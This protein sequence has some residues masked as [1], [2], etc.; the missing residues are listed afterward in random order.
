MLLSSHEMKL[1]C[2][3]DRLQ[4]QNGFS[5]VDDCIAII[6]GMAS[7]IYRRR[8]PKRR[9]EQSKQC[10]EQVIKVEDAE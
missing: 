7:R 1:V 10:I 2:K 4:L 3:T 8:S 9:A 5:L 6:T